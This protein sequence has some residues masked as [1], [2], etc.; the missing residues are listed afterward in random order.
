MILKN[1]F[2]IGFNKQEKA[3][4]KR[5]RTNTEIVITAADRGGEIAIQDC[6]TYHQE[7]LRILSDG[8][9]YTKICFQMSRIFCWKF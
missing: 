1:Q 7:A 6:K 4:L 2:K 3:A 9:Y 5:L 8:Q